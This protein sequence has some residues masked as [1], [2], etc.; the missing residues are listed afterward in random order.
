MPGFVLVHGAYHGAWCWDR[1][2]SKLRDA[3]HHVVAPDLPGHGADGL[4]LS[5]VSL[6]AYVER[7]A[8]T[9]RTMVAPPVVVGHSMAG[10]V[11]AEASERYPE[12]IERAIYL[13][14]YLPRHGESLAA[15]AGDDPGS[16]VEVERIEVDGAACVRVSDSVLRE[17]FYFDAS[18]DDLEMVRRKI[19]PQP[20]AVLKQP[21]TLSRERFDSVPRAYI[22][23]ADDRAI[24]PDLQRRMVAATPCRWVE[25]LDGGH[26]PFITAPDR[27]VDVLMRLAE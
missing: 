27:L 18:A 15:L 2:V 7:L 14:A 6:D 5:E 20:L 21:V 19:Q 8:E 3:G 13:T 1:V 16:S 24:T 17:A 23:C 4:P 12:L 10:V 26:S 22:H 25:T 11:L 9:A